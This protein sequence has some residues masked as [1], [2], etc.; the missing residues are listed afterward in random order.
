MAHNQAQ[1]RELLTTFRLQIQG[2]GLDPAPD[3]LLTIVFE[4]VALVLLAWVVLERRRDP[5][6]VV[7]DAK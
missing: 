5:T 4:G 3:A 2:N 7:A 1:L 6:A